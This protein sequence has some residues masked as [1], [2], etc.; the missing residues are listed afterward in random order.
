MSE[1]HTFYEDLEKIA[2]LLRAVAHGESGFE[3]TP[4]YSWAGKM[5]TSIEFITE[6]FTIRLFVDAGEPD[7][8]DCV[9]SPDGIHGNYDNWSEEVH[10]VDD[11]LDLLSEEEHE[12]L[13]HR[14]ESKSN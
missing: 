4:S 11:P 3:Y 5:T 14:F 13:I 2:A 9:I 6:G 12:L 8:V 7:Y 1:D 10:G